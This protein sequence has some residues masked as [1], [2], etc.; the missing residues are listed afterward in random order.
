MPANNSSTN[1]V[2]LSHPV[3]AWH[4]LFSYGSTMSA[5]LISHALEQHILL[6]SNT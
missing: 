4:A 6:L 2:G 5:Y 3:I 1:Y